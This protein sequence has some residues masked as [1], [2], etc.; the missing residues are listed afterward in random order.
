MSIPLPLWIRGLR[1]PREDA[2]HL[3]LDSGQEKFGILV[4]MAKPMAGTY[5]LTGSPY[6]GSE[7]HG[8]QGPWR[9]R[10]LGRKVIGLRSAPGLWELQLADGQVLALNWRRRQAGIRLVD[11]AVLGGDWRVTLPCDE[12]HDAGDLI[13]A[14]RQEEVDRP[15]RRRGRRQRGHTGRA[16]SFQESRKP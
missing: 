13:Q 1:R 14:R 6:K 8:S 7:P 15:E 4:L 11:E 16:R 10:L 5:V 9:H 3:Q 12:I 2:L